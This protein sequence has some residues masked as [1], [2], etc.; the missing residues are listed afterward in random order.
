MSAKP[1]IRHGDRLIL[2]SLTEADKKAILAFPYFDPAAPPVTLARLFELG[3]IKM[4]HGQQ[5]RVTQKGERLHHYLKAQA[6][7]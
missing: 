4:K 7:D 1:A 6:N 5:P 3:V 2:P